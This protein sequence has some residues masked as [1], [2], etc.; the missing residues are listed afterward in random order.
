MSTM[1]RRDPRGVAAQLGSACD[2]HRLVAAKETMTTQFSAHVRIDDV[3]S[4]VDSVA[5]LVEPPEAIFSF[6]PAEDSI[7]LWRIIRRH[8]V[9]RLDRERLC[10]E[11]RSRVLGGDT[12]ALTLWLFCCASD[13]AVSWC[14]MQSEWWF[15]SSLWFSLTEQFPAKL[16]VA[17]LSTFMR[18][19]DTLD[20]QDM[21]RLR[22]EF[23]EFDFD[24]ASFPDDIVERLLRE[25]EED[26]DPSWL[27]WVMKVA[28]TADRTTHL[29]F[30]TRLFH[31]VKST[32]SDEIY[33]YD[34]LDWMRRSNLL[35]KVDK[36]DLSAFIYLEE[37]FARNCWAPLA[38]KASLLDVV[39]FDVNLILKWITQ[40]KATRPHQASAITDNMC[41]AAWRRIGLAGVVSIV[42]ALPEA[43]WSN[44]LAIVLC[45]SHPH[46]LTQFKHVFVSVK[47]LELQREAPYR[48]LS[49]G[50]VVT[51]QDLPEKVVSDEETEF[52]RL[53]L[54]RMKKSWKYEWHLMMPLWTQAIAQQL[55]F[56]LK[57]YLPRVLIY[58]IIEQ[59]TAATN[60][61]KEPLY[62]R[63]GNGVKAMHELI[64]ANRN[65][66]KAKR[67]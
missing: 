24:G 65:R 48:Y 2:H 1:L 29:M 14:L 9:P 42:E 44:S 53:V 4:L 13:E 39:P 51:A 37:N 34:L 62:Y 25:Q 50:L 55:L 49:A 60:K 11:A 35:N 16:V 15:H 5:H 54:W 3:C 57:Q 23:G 10:A 33:E 52:A 12:T 38:L 21:S 6:R 41:E 56:C 18:Q 22:E 28:G 59:V 7:E 63:F 58:L 64:C 17:Q 45:D 20:G 66:K 26:L 36:V 43:L 46:L 19:S 32:S 27:A 67:E 8:F 31:L 61:V 30:A 40:V 47:V